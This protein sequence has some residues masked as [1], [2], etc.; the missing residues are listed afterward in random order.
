ML[1]LHSTPKV[2]WSEKERFGQ[3]R[4][5]HGA[6]MQNAAVLINGGVDDGMAGAAVFGLDVKDLVSDLY[7]RVK[8]GAHR[9][10]CSSSM[11]SSEGCENPINGEFI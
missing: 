5:I 1:F 11:R 7:V 2:L 6:A 3:L 8:P 4:I 9:A 10:K